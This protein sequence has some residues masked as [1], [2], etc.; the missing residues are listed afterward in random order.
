MEDFV[1]RVLGK[2]SIHQSKLDCVKNVISKIKETNDQDYKNI[3]G[4]YLL[5]Y[6]F[7]CSRDSKGRKLSKVEI[8]DACVQIRN[9]GLLYI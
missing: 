1:D 5:A 7:E 6:Q 9:V 4:L 2:L 8:A 3:L